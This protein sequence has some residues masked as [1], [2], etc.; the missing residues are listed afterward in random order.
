MQ[1]WAFGSTSGGGEHLGQGGGELGDADRTRDIDLYNRAE[2]EE[3]GWF[4]S[5]LLV[6]TGAVEVAGVALAGTGPVAGLGQI[7]RNGAVQLDELAGQRP[8]RRERVAE[9][10]VVEQLRAVL[11]RAAM[12]RVPLAW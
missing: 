1:I 9:P 12:R 3:A 10:G 5:Q 7:Q 2:P 6:A 11:T 4:T 8:R